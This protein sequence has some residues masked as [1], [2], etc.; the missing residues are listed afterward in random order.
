MSTIPHV[1]TD[2]PRRMGRSPGRALTIALAATAFLTALPSRAAAGPITFTFEGTVTAV[3]PL[4]GAGTFAPGDVLTGSLTYDSALIDTNVSSSVGR[5]EP[6]SSLVFSIDGYSATFVDG[7]GYVNVTNGP[8]GGDNLAFR[9]DVTGPTVNGFKP[10]NLQFGLTDATGTAL[11]SD[12]LPLA[13]STS[14]F[15]LNQFFFT[16]TNRANPYDLTSGG[17]NFTG[18]QGTFTGSAGPTPVPEPATFTLLSCGLA[19]SLLRWR[20]KRR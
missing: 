5:Y 3:S 20:R 11:S 2:V 17:T 9:G 10:F 12:A 6:I 14:Q 4:L 15:T 8:P 19:G 1:T 13:F 16:F 18:V 7:T